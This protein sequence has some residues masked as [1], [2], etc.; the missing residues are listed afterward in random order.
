MQQ[1]VISALEQDK[2]RLVLF[3]TGG[4]FDAVDDIPV[5]ERHPLIAEYLQV[6]YTLAID[7]NGTEILLR[8]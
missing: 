1:E 7:I 5:E 6:N 8:K 4:W 3:K 2:T